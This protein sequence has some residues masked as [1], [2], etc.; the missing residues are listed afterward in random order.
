M[1][2]EKKTTYKDYIDKN[3]AGNAQSYKISSPLHYAGIIAKAMEPFWFF[4]GKMETE[5]CQP[6]LDKIPVV[7]PVYVSGLARS[8]T[9]I[10]LELLHHSNVF[11][12]FTYQYYPFISF[13]LI[14]NMIVGSRGGGEAVE[15][16][17]LDRIK[18]TAKSPEAIEEMI[19]MHFFPGRI[20]DPDISSVLTEKD[21][22]PA[23]ESF[24]KN[25]I[26]KML[27]LGKKE[28]YL[29][30]GNYN[31]ARIPYIH[32]LY[33]DARFIVLIREPE[34]HIAS[35]M[36]QHYL[37]CKVANPRVLRYMKQIG[38]YEFGPHRIP[39]NYNSAEK[40]KKIVQ[41]WTE[42]SEIEGWARLWSD[43]YE[44]L[45]NTLSSYPH[46]SKNILVIRYEDLC[47]APL[48][49][50]KK[51][52]DFCDVA[53]SGEIKNFAANISA[54]DYYEAGF[55]EDEKKKIQEITQRTRNLFYG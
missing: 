18:V 53:F 4:L 54:P 21:S 2:Q 24:Y 38:H 10:T 11:S 37:F 30:K 42:N 22:N 49:Y 14:W 28:R 5:Y 31:L 25:S 52:T 8:G 16:A 26:R 3:V 41:A 23:F 35:L 17:H 19:W 50:A 1:K 6:K 40:A 47:A 7:K 46:L 36:K 20:T 34:A 29:A 27:L 13:P 12:S 45:H 9:T 39:P 51:I 33:P 48:D 43:T 44:F 32:K 15:R 55:T